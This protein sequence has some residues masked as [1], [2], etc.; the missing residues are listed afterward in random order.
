MRHFRILL[1]AILLCG[2]FSCW[3]EKDIVPRPKGYFRIDLPE[4]NYKRWSADAPYSFEIPDYVNMLP[5]S[6][7]NVESFWYNMDFSPFRA[8]IH[9]SYKKVNG[10]LDEY[11]MQC[12]EM[13][14]QHQVKANAMKESPVLNDSSKVYGLIYEFGGNTASSVQFYL[15][16]SS[17]HFVRGALYFWTRPNADSLAPSLR[18][19]TDDVYRMVESFRWEDMK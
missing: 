5:D 6:G 12:R 10:N 8:V 19:I 1:P 15:T 14:I 7:K 18:F 4:K 11:L 16:D 3:E 9:L 13:A 17:R 2:L